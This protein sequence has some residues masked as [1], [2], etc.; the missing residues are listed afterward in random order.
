M[1]I[2]Y[3]PLVLTAVAFLLFLSGCSEPVDRMITADG[4]A[5]TGELLSIEG[6]V[7]TFTPSSSVTLDRSSA[8]IFSSEGS[9]ERGTL[10]YSEGVFHIS[11]AGGAESFAAEEIEMVV[12]SSPS[13]EVVSSLTVPAWD[14]WINSGIDVRE[15]DIITVTA[16]GNVTMETGTCGP[17]GLEMYSTTTALVPGATNGQ[18][19]MRIAESPGVAVGAEWTGPATGSGQL[20]FAVNLPVSSPEPD[21]GGVFSVDIVRSCGPGPGTAVLYPAAG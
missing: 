19:V 13:L 14:G 16:S 5:V 17:E 15:G 12:W 8:R 3:Y 4:L 9:S 11:S 7:V 18:L 20:Y 21:D 1:T 2:K 10:S 6:S